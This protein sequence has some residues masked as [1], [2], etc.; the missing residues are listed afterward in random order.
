MKCSTSL[1]TFKAVAISLYIRHPLL[2]HWQQVKETKAGGEGESDGAGESKKEVGTDEGEPGEKKEGKP[3]D[4]K[5]DGSEKEE[6]VKGIPS[7]WLTAFR[8]A[9]VL[10]SMVKVR[11]VHMLHRS[12]SIY[13]YPYRQCVRMSQSHQGLPGLVMLSTFPSFFTTYSLHSLN[14]IESD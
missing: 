13:V 7:F 3:D 5:E 2:P 11:E 12:Y 8:N 4:V 14:S 10:E 1:L 9:E 6:D